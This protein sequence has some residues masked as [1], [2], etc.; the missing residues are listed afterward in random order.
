MT[1]PSA[2]A[3]T[4]ELAFELEHFG[5]TA[6]DRLELSGR[7]FGV[8]GRRFVRPVLNME[9]G[10]HRRRLIA[11]LDHKPWSAQ[12]GGPWI[13]A[14]PWRGDVHEAGP[15]TLALGA[16]LVLELPP[17]GHA[18]AGERLTPLAGRQVAPRRE[19]GSVTPRHARPIA[20][21]TEEARLER[22]LAAERT[23]ATDLEASLAQLQGRLQE[24]DEAA[25]ARA[26]EAARG[27]E[28]RAREQAGRA[29]A[30]AAELESARERLAQLADHEQRGVERAR[31]VVRL[32]AELATARADAEARVA[33][34]ATAQ[35]A[36][37][38]RLAEVEKAHAEMQR[39]VAELESA[40]E[41][42]HRRLEATDAARA[43][44]ERRL[45]EADPERAERRA[46]A[47]DA[48]R[49]EAAQ[50]ADEAVAARKAAERR[51]AEEV[52]ERERLAAELQSALRQLRRAEERTTAAPGPPSTRYRRP[53]APPQRTPQLTWATRAV[54]VAL[55]LVLLAVFA[56]VIRAIA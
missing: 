29:E 56:L 38:R 14:F 42:F 1:P 3:D 34:A 51:L 44:A 26:G 20:K 19:P 33:Q 36:A 31:D 39:R 22:A 27:A 50:L 4:G 30:L 46:A 9:V 5:W 48:A 18:A 17:P 8:R 55:V 23:R 15:A 2:A 54:A 7:W 45:T 12:D 49:A 37:E 16:D 25:E 40:G 24:A 13:A 32:E 47:A 52:A 10:E 28:D 6:D 21:E 11:V 41:R 53:G 43:E 35:Q